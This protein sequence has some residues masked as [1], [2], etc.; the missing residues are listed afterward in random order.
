MSNK[1]TEKL[2]AIDRIVRSVSPVTMFEGTKVVLSLV[3]GFEKF[4]TRPYH[5]YETWSDGWRVSGYG[6]EVERE[7]LDD[8]VA[9]WV[10][11]VREARGESS[12]GGVPICPD[13]GNDEFLHNRSG[14][15]GEITHEM[16]KHCG[17]MLLYYNK[18]RS[19]ERKS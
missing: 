9:L 19:A 4:N 15:G 12:G 3:N 1:S 17:A 10:A 2:N 5:N 13:C 7:D 6:I 18:N 8:A 11:K 16:C 14:F